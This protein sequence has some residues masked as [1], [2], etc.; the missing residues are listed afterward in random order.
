MQRKNMPKEFM[1]IESKPENWSVYIIEADDGSYY[2][3]VSTDVER[4][5]EEHCSGN[6]GARYFLGRKPKA[7]VYVEGGHDRSSAHQRESQI[8][9]LNRKQKEKLVCHGPGPDR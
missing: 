7:V 4:R 8:K 6:R 3:G 5:F 9:K 1:I 2:T